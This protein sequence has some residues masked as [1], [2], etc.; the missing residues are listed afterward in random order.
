MNDCIF[1][2]IINHEIPGKIVYEDD[3]CLAFLDLSQT[4]DGHTL[5]IPKKHYDHILDVD[6]DTL[7]HMMKV[8]QVV[9]KNIE[10]KLGAKGFNIVSNMNE[11]AGQSVHHFHIHI[12]PRYSESDGFKAIYTDRSNE[13]DLQNI[14][15]KLTK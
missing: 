3:I 5:V 13:V 8:V 12:I 1:C 11:I 2:K 7:G 10:D 15:T 4:T 9:A 6:S 14:Y